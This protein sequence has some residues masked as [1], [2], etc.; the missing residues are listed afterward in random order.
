MINKT[1][2]AVLLLVSGFQ[3]L[4]QKKGEQGSASLQTT[5]LNPDEKA[6]REAARMKD[7]LNLSNEQE[8]GWESAALERMSATAP[9]REKLKGAT[10][11]EERQELRKKMRENKVAFDTKIASLLTPEQQTKLREERARRHALKGHKGRDIR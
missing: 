1:L 10:T 8:R 2:F 4:A 11:P 7:L 9:M 5:D 6:R 3:G